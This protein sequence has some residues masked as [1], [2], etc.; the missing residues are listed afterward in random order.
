MAEGNM[1]APV[2]AA[3]GAA[4]QHQM[5]REWVR[6]GFTPE[7]AMELVKAVIMAVL[8]KEGLC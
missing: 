1:S 2:F 5:Y 8:K 3:A 4:E 6:V 7:Q